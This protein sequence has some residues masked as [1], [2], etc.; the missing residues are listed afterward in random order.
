[1]FPCTLIPG[2]VGWLIFSLIVHTLLIG[3]PVLGL[4][5]LAYYLLS[6]PARRQE[7]TR[8]F[9]HLVEN[10]L[11]TG[12]PV[13]P[14]LVSLAES[15]D[16]TL[17]LRFHLTAAYVEEG[18][19]LGTALEKSALL[20]RPVLAM[21]AAG[22]K[23]GDLRQVL[24]ACRMQLQ[25]ATASLNGALNYFFVLM[26]GLAPLVVFLSWVL[27]IIVAPKMQ[28]VFHG[29]STSGGNSFWLDFMQISLRCGVWVQSAL[30]VGLLGAAILYLSGPGLPRW[31]RRLTN[32]VGDGIAWLVPWKRKRMQRNFAALL[33]VLLDY[34]VPEPVAV[35]LAA[36]GAGNDVFSR[37]A[38]RVV[39]RLAV[40]EPLTRA[41]AA[42]D[43]A[44]EFHW[45][46]TNA[47][48]TRGGFTTA[49][50]GWFE[51]LD[52]RAFQQEQAT[53][54]LISTGLV[55]VNGTVVGCICAG[56][57]GSLISLIEQAGL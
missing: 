47:T 8:L 56:L 1:M 44:G 28:E 14:A 33:A 21:F 19:R 32:P 27:L 40:G 10:C 9:L 42:L 12:R 31:L 26:V 22:E 35:Q 6:L 25:D 30:L 7:R 18:D 37:R 16:R 38:Q 13:E 49:L 4:T 57:F 24:P 51:T 17:G 36:G 50:R 43:D 34:H 53:A 48:A 41:V 29:M 39:E 54:H 3:L 52:A 55:V 20:P 5:C 2:G 46:L 45:R 11:R 23:L 15:G